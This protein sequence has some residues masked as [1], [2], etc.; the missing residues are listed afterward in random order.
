MVRFRPDLGSMVREFAATIVGCLSSLIEGLD[1]TGYL[2]G[3]LARELPVKVPAGF[4]G[5][6]WLPATDRGRG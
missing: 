6:R 4:G 1:T 5:G 3:W 2:R